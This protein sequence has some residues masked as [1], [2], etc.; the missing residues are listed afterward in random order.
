MYRLLYVVLF[1]VVVSCTPQQ[2]LRRAFVGKPLSAMEAE[3]GKAVTVFENAGD[4]VYIFEKTKNLKS[5]EINQGKLAL[6]PMVT[7]KVIK[8][9]KYYVTVVDDKIKSVKIEN[10]YERK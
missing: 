3:F 9:E 7:P 1:L 8:T 6:D 10:E 4:S 5:T 2:K